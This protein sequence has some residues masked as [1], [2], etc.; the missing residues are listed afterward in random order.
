[1]SA[2][3]MESE[4]VLQGGDGAALESEEP[5][6]GAAAESPGSSM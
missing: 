6:S 2:L 3:G 5:E 4:S 1:L